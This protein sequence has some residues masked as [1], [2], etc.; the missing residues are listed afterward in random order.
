MEYQAHTTSKGEDREH[1]LRDNP[2]DSKILNTQVQTLSE[3]QC[4]GRT[5]VDPLQSCTD[6]VMLLCQA[7]IAFKSLPPS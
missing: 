3:G 6:H 2:G 5:S 7:Q 4:V 1:S